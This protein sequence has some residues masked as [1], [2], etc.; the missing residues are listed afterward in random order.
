MRALFERKVQSGASVEMAREPRALAREDYAYGVSRLPNREQPEPVPYFPLLGDSGFIVS[1]T[2][3]RFRT[4]CHREFKRKKQANKC[5]V[6]FQSLEWV[7]AKRSGF[8][9]LYCCLVNQVPQLA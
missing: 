8:W 5:R 4:M 6:I 7:G 1:L 2:C 9:H 3:A